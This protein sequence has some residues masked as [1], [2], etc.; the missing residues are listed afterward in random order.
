MLAYKCSVLVGP[1][2]QKLFA[3]LSY[4]AGTVKQALFGMNKGLGMARRR[5]IQIGQDVAQML[6]RQRR[7][8]RSDRSA[9][10]TGGLA[11]PNA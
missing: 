2:L 5:H 1:A 3:G 7:A 9:C 4:I 6:L 11:A 8:N 10:D